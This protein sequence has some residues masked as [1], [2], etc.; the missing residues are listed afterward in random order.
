MVYQEEMGGN[1]FRA[2]FC[3]WRTE[4]IERFIECQAFLWSDD[5]APPPAP[6]PVSELDRRHTGR[7]RNTVDEAC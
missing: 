7:L 4:N 5:S 2:F 6:S 3:V 1:I